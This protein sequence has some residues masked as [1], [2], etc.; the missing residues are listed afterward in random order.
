[1]SKIAV[2][3]P[4]YKRPDKLKRLLRSLDKQTYK[5]FD[6]FIYFDN[7]DYE[8]SLHIDP[9]NYSF[10]IYTTVN[11][12]Q[13]YVIGSWNHFFSTSTG[14]EAVQWLVDDVELTNNFLEEA[15]N[16]LI[17]NFPD[18]DGVI[19]TKQACPGHSNYTFK[20]YGQAMIGRKF[21]E[22]YKDVNYQVCCP[23]YFHFYQDEELWMYASSLNKFIEC[24][25]ALLYHYH[26]AFAKEEIDSTHPIVRGNVMVED[27]TIYNQ[28]RSQGLIWGKTWD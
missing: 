24:P 7:C 11:T 5:D 12:E 6:V 22:R 26:P 27:K 18:T 23:H 21:I 4:T 17:K 10:H 3:I 1:M 25:T 15:Y 14:Y 8:S 28:R 19:G 2:V 20:W 16:C 9:L 13:K